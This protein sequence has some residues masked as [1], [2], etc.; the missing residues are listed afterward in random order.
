MFLYSG[1]GE[2]PLEYTRLGGQFIRLKESMKKG[3][4]IRI[5]WSINQQKIIK[6]NIEDLGD[7]QIERASREISNQEAALDFFHTFRLNGNLFE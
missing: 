4:Q 3:D 6:L 2:N 7:L 5:N 1:Y